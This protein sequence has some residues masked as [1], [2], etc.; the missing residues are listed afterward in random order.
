VVKIGDGWLE[1]KLYSLKAGLPNES[2]TL[3]DITTVNC[4][5]AEIQVLETPQA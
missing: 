2:N 1:Q 5:R 3:H 4:L